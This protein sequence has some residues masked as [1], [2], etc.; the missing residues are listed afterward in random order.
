MAPVTAAPVLS[1]AGAL[2]F[3]FGL[4]FVAVT[5]FG[6]VL[7]VRLLHPLLVRYAMAR[8]NA[9]SAH[10]VPTP[11]GGGLAVLAAV[12]LAAWLGASALGADGLTA[13]GFGPGS[14]F[15]VDPEDVARLWTVLGAAVLVGAVGAL[16]DLRPLPPL[17]RLALQFVGAG[18][19]VSAL[20]DGARVLP[21]IPLAAERLLLVIGGAWFMNLTNFMDG[22]DWLTVADT[23]PVTAALS[24]FW[25]FGL[26][27]APAGLVALSLLGATLGFAP[28]NR[29]VARLFLGDV[30]S[31]AIGLLVASALYDLANHGGLVAATVLPLYPIAD[32]GVTLLWRLRRREAVWQA[33]RHHFYQVA[34]AR[35]LPV[36][37]VLARIAVANLALVVIAGASLFQDNPALGGLDLLL[38]VGVV[39]VLLRA[40]A[41][42]RPAGLAAPPDAEA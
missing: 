7:L 25:F 18:L 12:V 14:P 11:Q 4:L 37:D 16:D 19:A 23:V 39:A 40:L 21:W 35:G 5:A 31:L 13:L 17:P 27:S 29:P 41:R 15:A 30:G 22:M 26:V 34:V 10:T 42:G 9:R 38:G 2:L 3:G 8:P 6:A 24:F 36:R 33:H 32:S 1:G 20:P 28:F